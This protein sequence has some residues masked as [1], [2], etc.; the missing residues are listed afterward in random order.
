MRFCGQKLYVA[1]WWV[2]R[3]P[4]IIICNTRQ[5]HSHY[6]D[7]SRTPSMFTIFH[8]HFISPSP[9]PFLT[10]SSVAHFDALNNITQTTLRNKFCIFVV[11]KER[12][13]PH[14]TNQTTVNMT[15]EDATPLMAKTGKEESNDEAP[16]R[17]WRSKDW[18]LFA[19]PRKNS[20]TLVWQKSKL[21]QACGSLNN[22][23]FPALC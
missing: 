4:N 17:R 11:R 23:S 2:I 18:A 22:T 13:T 1:E 16:R 20:R 7:L 15:Y 3:W 12:K 14:D 9:H 5:H 19:K 6:H 21:N 10:P 8:R